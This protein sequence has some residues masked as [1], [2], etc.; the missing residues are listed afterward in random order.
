MMTPMNAMVGMTSMN[1]KKPS[2]GWEG[3]AGWEGISG[4]GVS[5]NFTINMSL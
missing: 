3:V 4:R 1:T 5:T 2:T